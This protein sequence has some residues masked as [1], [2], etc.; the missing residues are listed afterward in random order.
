MSDAAIA[1][2]IQLASRATY[3]MVENGGILY[4]VLTIDGFLSGWSAAIVMRPANLPG[5]DPVAAAYG[6]GL[7]Y[8][9]THVGVDCS[10]LATLAQAYGAFLAAYIAGEPLPQLPLPPATPAGSNLVPGVLHADAP[11]IPLPPPPPPGYGSDATTAP[12]ATPAPTVTPTPP[13]PVT[14]TPATTTTTTT[15]DGSGVLAAAKPQFIAAA[16]GAIDLGGAIGGLASATVTFGISLAVEAIVGVL[17]GGLFGGGDIKQ[18]QQDLQNLRTALAQTA[19]ELERFSWS[20]ADGLGRTWQAV[21]DIWDNFLDGLWSALKGLWNALWVVVSSVLPKIIQILKDL[22]N[23]LDSIYLKYILPIMRYLLLIRQVLALLRALGVPI[24]SKLDRIL[25]QIQGALFSPFLY[26]LRSLNGYG[27]WFNFILTSNLVLQRPLFLNTMYAYQ[28]DWIN[29][30]Y[31]AQSGQLGPVGVLGPAAQ[32]T[33]NYASWLAAGGATGGTTDTTQ[34]VMTVAEACAWITVF[35]TTGSG[36]LA[37]TA[38]QTLVL[39]NQQ[40]GQ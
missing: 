21:A 4:P 10:Q 23:F 40:L 5:T 13:P 6:E 34:Q 38:Q 22:R 31:T 33:S 35:A 32:G 18:V 11:P 20:I 8:C 12:T 30:F 3:V 16:G 2:S 9:Q 29:M 28:A 27:G 7:Y 25:G 14:P 17:F 39:V 1:M 37:D 24:A 26:L 36:E 15:T 19:D